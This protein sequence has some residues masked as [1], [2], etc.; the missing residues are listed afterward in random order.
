MLAGSFAFAALR[1]ASLALLVFGSTL[2]VGAGYLGLAVAPGL[3]TACAAAALGGAGNG[4]QWVAVISAVQELTVARMQARVLGVLESIGAAMPGLG[5]VV[6]ALIATAQDPRAA[7]LVAGLGVI[8]VVALAV[9]LV[10]T[11]W[12]ERARIAE[13]DSED[14]VV[15]V[16]RPRDYGLQPRKSG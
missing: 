11:R 12:A 10:G 9:P 14:E 13:D 15:V 1:Q 16:L 4:V 6:G 5:Y 2:T 7:F 8:G 3:A